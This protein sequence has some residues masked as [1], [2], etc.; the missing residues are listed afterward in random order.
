MIIISECSKLAQKGAWLGRNGNPL[1]IVQ[2]ENFTKLPNG[3]YA[4]TRI[5]LRE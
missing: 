2:E 5:C 4:Q 1:R 3:I